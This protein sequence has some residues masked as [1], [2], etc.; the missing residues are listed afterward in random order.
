MKILVYI[1]SMKPAGGIERVVSNLVNNWIDDHQ[2]IILVKDEL[3]SFYDLDSRIRFI[4]LNKPLELK[5]NSKLS[6]FLNMLVSLVITH[7]ELKKTINSNCSDVIYTTNP[8]NSMEIC[9]IG[10]KYLKKLIISEHGS[11]L[12]YNK[13]YNSIKKIVYPKAYKISVPTTLDTEL[14]IKEEYP[15]VFI[16]HLSTFK[17]NS[18]NDMSKKQ[19]LNIGRLTKDK[20]QIELLRI[21]KLIV[22]E[23]KHNDWNLLIV[24]IGEEE[25]NLMNYIKMN[26]LI[27]TVNILKPS[28]NVKQFFEDSSIFA[29]TSEF[30]GFGM[31]LLEAMSF[32]VP[33]VSFNC[34]SGPRDIIDNGINGY[35]IENRNNEDFKNS[36]LSL[37]YDYDLREKFSNSSF[38]KANNWDNLEVLKKWNELFENINS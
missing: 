33:C 29:F 17:N 13:V 15:A 7:K 28:K 14:Y 9:L 23:K 21:W 27:S 11:K 20:Q 6:R 19:I 36:L 32:G 26:N 24:G 18:K 3:N 1:N 34:P 8:I 25:L 38:L 10:S 35:L 30:E 5:M 16:P 12:G 22:D 37:M 31:V 2:I 4:S